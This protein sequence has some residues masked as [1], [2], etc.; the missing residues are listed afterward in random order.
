MG[1]FRVLLRF[2]NLASK[3]DCSNPFSFRDVTFFV[4]FFLQNYSK[5][6]STKK[7]AKFETTNLMK[8]QP[9]GQRLPRRLKLTFELHGVAFHSTEVFL[10]QFRKNLRTCTEEP[11]AGSFLKQRNSLSKQVDN[12]ACVL[13]SSNDKNYFR[14]N[15]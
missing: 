8:T 12:A 1:T 15:F 11:R 13:G 3:Y 9:Y 4:I 2:A 7:F 5:K 10:N 6:L 14:R